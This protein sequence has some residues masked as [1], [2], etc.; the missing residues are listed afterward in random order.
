MSA[1]LDEVTCASLPPQALGVLADL[2]RSPEIRVVL[3]G[4]RAWVRWPAGDE[5]VLRRV[6]PVR[7]V[8]LYA[9]RGHHW[10]Q[11]GRHLPEWELPA[12]LDGEGVPL[13]RALIPTR[14]DVVEP[15]EDP[16]EPA[17]LRLVRDGRV[18]PASALRCSVEQLARWAEMIPSGRLAALL[19]ATD[20][21]RVMV[22]GH[23]L[24][25]LA[26]TERFWGESLLLPLG[27][28]PDPD[29]QDHVLR[30]A[31]GI[32]D[33]DLAVFGCAGYEVVPRAVFRPLNRSGIRLAQGDRPE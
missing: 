4:P 7:G 19:A 12:E 14:V 27:F 17:P 29:L 16:P 21:P 18:R 20:G 5:R 31:L 2:R 25:G 28:R 3:A 1:T 24:P 8:R 33:G 26:G 6:L 13:S 23:P 10:Y 15:D 11:P 32:G 22:L 9:R 30:R